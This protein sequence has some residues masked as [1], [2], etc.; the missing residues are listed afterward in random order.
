MV[1]SPMFALE[2]TS[3]GH[4]RTR[5]L[6]AA[7]T[8]RRR[9]AIIVVC[10]KSARTMYRT[11]YPR[12][13]GLMDRYRAGAAMMWRCLISIVGLTLSFALPFA[14]S[15]SLGVATDHFLVLLDG[16]IAV[17]DLAVSIVG[18]RATTAVG[19]VAVHNSF[20]V[21]SSLPV[22]K[23]MQISKMCSKF[24]RRRLKKKTASESIASNK[25]LA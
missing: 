13:N 9:I 12:C 15:V 5:G 4:W 20:V 21:N 11:R 19:I 23:P 22:I 1:R 14:L 18:R 8:N 3:E 24:A 16:T 17:L 6:G 7:N 2:G 10:Q 25:S